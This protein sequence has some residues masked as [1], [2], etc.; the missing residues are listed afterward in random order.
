[1]I[2]DTF[3]EEIVDAELV[4][5]EGEALAVV[6]EPAPRIVVDQHTILHP[7]QAL[8]TAADGPLYIELDLRIS[9]ETSALLKRSAP[10]ETGPMKAFRAWCAE[11]RDEQDG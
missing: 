6:Q 11:Q 4:E 1:M 7:G 3:E 2:H 10:I 5:G 8:P 9:P